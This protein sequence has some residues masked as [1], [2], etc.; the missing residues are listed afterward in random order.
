[1]SR[2]SPS[3]GGEG[4]RVAELPHDRE[5][6]GH[7][8]GGLYVVVLDLPEYRDEEQELLVP[9]DT[10]HVRVYLRMQCRLARL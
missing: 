9:H 6:G 8:L 10:L 5:T 4:P 3:R 1:M 7:E 2:A